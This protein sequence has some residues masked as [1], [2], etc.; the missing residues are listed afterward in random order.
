MREEGL[1]VTG[2]TAR[3]EVS[4]LERGWEGWARARTASTSERR[5]EGG[6]EGGCRGRHHLHCSLHNW[7]NLLPGGLSSPTDICCRFGCCSAGQQLPN[8]LIRPL[9]DSSSRQWQTPAVRQTSSGL[10]K[11]RKRLRTSM[12]EIVV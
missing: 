4:A 11:L 7:S 6:R 5:R 10:S 8:L 9:Q 1:L 2:L 3:V 12:P